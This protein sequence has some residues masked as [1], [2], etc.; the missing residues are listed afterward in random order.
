MVFSDLEYLE[1]S[2]VYTINESNFFTVDYPCGKLGKRVYNVCL[3][4][5]ENFKF[6]AYKFK[7]FKFCSE[8]NNSE[9]INFFYSK[10]FA[11]LFFFSLLL[12][13]VIISYSSL[14]LHE[15]MKKGR[16]PLSEPNL[17]VLKILSDIK[18]KNRKK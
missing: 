15:R 3:T 4:F 18:S 12:A 5:D 10:K 2:F 8:I 14:S 16:E 13:L 7:A 1:K 17:L 6:P 11:F 9:E